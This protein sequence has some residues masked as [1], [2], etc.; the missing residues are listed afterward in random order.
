MLLVTYLMLLQ[1]MRNSLHMSWVKEADCNKTKN[2]KVSSI[3]MLIKYLAANLPLL[4]QLAQVHMGCSI[5][6]TMF[7]SHLKQSLVHIQCSMQFSVLLV[8][9]ALS[10]CNYELCYF[11]KAVAYT[12][13][14][15]RKLLLCFS[16]DPL[17]WTRGS[18]FPCN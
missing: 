1:L 18:N 8:V 13:V 15:E 16:L 9:R 14:F 12:F 5:I 7:T 6:K 4:L 3:G 17:A 10:V 2:F 11:S